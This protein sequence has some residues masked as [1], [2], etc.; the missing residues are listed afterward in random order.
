MKIWENDEFRR[1]DLPLNIGIVIFGYVGNNIYKGVEKPISNL[2]AFAL[3]YDSA[4]FLF[5]FPTHDELA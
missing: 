1:A 4:Q 2:E 5:I 3:D